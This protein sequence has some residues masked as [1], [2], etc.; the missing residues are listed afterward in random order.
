[1]ALSIR[2]LR[3]FMYWI[4]N[5]RFIQYSF[6]DDSEV[7]IKRFPIAFKVIPKGVSSF[8][9]IGYRRQLH[10]Y[11]F[12]CQQL[13]K[14]PYASHLLTLLKL[15]DKYIYLYIFVY[16]YHLL[17]NNLTGNLFHICRLF[18]QNL[19]HIIHVYWIIQGLYPVSV[20]RFQLIYTKIVPFY[21]IY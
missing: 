13:Y 4:L 1:M 18:L 15:L 7:T 12:Y 3:F 2:H 8:A 11:I 20:C 14:P 21:D 19:Y 9:R 16:N 6:F 10:D 17:V 5:Y